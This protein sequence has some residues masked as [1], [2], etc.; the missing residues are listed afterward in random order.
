M[1]KKFLILGLLLIVGAGG[2]FF[3]RQKSVGGPLTS[4]DNPTSFAQLMALGQD[5]SCT[6]ESTDEIGNAHRGT[7][8]VTD[9]GNS[10]RGD[11]MMTSSEGE[12]TSHMIR[13]GEYSYMWGTTDGQGFKM[14]LDPN[15]EQLFPEEAGEETTAQFA[16][17]E[18]QELNFECQPWRPDHN[19]FAPPS[20]VE[21]T[22]LSAQ[23]EVM[24]EQ[25]QEVPEKTELDCS[26]CEQVPAGEARTS[27]LTSLSC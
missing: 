24:M 14:K 17:D 21:F 11:F 3:L 7:V 12:Q 2:A 6:F 18:N 22:D 16:Y 8:F 13:S 9:Q 5:Y 10:F 4:I 19:L 27:C 1:N 20:D 25:M 15:D 26:L 23:M